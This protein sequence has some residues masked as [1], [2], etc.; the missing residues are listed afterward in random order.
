MNVSNVLERPAGQLQILQTGKQP[1]GNSLQV[2]ERQTLTLAPNVTRR[3]HPRSSAPRTK[4]LRATYPPATVDP[5][6]TFQSFVSDRGHP[7]S[8]ST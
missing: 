3:K 1:L 8:W 6:G 7:A 5:R 2:S 4:H